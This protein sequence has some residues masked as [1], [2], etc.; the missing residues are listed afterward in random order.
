VWHYLVREDQQKRQIYLN[1]RIYL[2]GFYH[3][4]D[5]VG[6]DI[7]KIEG[8]YEL[9]EEK[10]AYGKEVRLTNNPAEDSFPARSPDGEKIAFCSDRDGNFEIYIRTIDSLE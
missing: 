7:F 2:V 4:H 6:S 1:Q 9:I 3:N 10:E 8:T 5:L